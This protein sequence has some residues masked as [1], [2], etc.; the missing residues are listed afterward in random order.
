MSQAAESP[1]GR[2]ISIAHL[3]LLIPWVA[4]V[5]GSWSQIEDNSFLWHVRAGSLQA[6]QGVVF[7]TDPFSFTMFGEPWLTQSWLVELL[8]GW[9]EVLTGLGFVPYMLLLVTA[10]TFVAIG[11]TAYGKSQSV[12]ATALVVIASVFALVSFLVPRPVVFS[13]L[14]MALV[15]L[16]WDRPSTR[17]AVPFLVWI[18]AAAHASFVIGLAYIGLTLIMNREWREWPK[19]VVAGLVTLGTAHGLGVATFLLDF[20]VSSEA[21]QYLS[22]WRKPDLIEP[23]FLPLAG[24][25]VLIVIGAFRNRIFPRHLWLVVPFL[26][27][28]M[29]SVRAIPAAWLALVPLVATSLSGLEIGARPSQRRG[30]AAIFAIL[31]LVLPFLLIADAQ[32]SSTRFPIAALPALEDVPT[33]HD[34]VVGGYLIWAEPERLVYVDDRAELYGPRLGELVRIRRGELDW[35]P[36]FRRDG[37]EQVLL[38]VGE[39]LTESLIDAGWQATYSDGSFAVLRP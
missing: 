21:L 14:L 15:I 37:I 2:R 33:F 13:Y 29:T 3:V 27:L 34:D 35:E 32:L 10:L 5:V 30:V 38:G 12:P 4:L 31:V 26:L 20:G 24:G 23:A 1:H 22:E 39:P 7:T 6:D 28:G 16:A 8:Y 25:V 19:A 9:L 18:W 17:W 36:I 11:M